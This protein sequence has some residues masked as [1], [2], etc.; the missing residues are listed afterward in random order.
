MQLSTL[1]TL[2]LTLLLSVTT[3]VFAQTATYKGDGT[4]EKPYL[5]SQFTGN[6][7]LLSKIIEGEKIYIIGKF[8]GYGANGRTLLKDA[9]A[10]E[11]LLMVGDTVFAKLNDGT[12]VAPGTDGTS[13][14]GPGYVIAT[15]KNVASK[16]RALQ[17]GK[18]YEWYG[19]YTM[20]EA[21]E[22]FVF[23]IEDVMAD[24]TSVSALKVS[25]LASKAVYDLSGR[26]VQA[27]YQPATL[28]QGLYIVGGAKV[29]VR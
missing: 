19:T 14:E 12:E 24:P 17:Q 2:L 18:T 27:V 5:I 11:H 3:A 21:A 4:K 29:L 10:D 15:D 22:D 13:T 26:L 16:V 6:E 28:P 7:D 8:V 25:P 1:K 9:P 23:T 20:D